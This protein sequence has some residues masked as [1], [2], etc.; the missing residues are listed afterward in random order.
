[1]KR[2]RNLTVFAHCHGA[3]VFLKLEEM[4]QDKMKELGYTADERNI[5]QK[6][7]FC[8]AYAPL[9]PVGINKSNVINFASAWDDAI[10]SSREK[11]EEKHE[12][13]AHDNIFSQFIRTMRTN[14]NTKEG[15]GFDNM[16]LSFSLAPVG[17]I[18]FQY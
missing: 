12:V 18:L 1:M 14:L 13:K 15:P 3:Y 9:T 6:Q 11:T 2:I 8:V 5:I 4:M 7:L 10:N 16:V 17:L